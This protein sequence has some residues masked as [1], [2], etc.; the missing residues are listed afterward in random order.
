[1]KPTYVAEFVHVCTKFEWNQTISKI[2]SISRQYSKNGQQEQN[3]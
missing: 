2:L 3:S 1:L